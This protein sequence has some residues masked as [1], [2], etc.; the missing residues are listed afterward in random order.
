V[1][2]GFVDQQEACSAGERTTRAYVD[3]LRQ[4]R[5]PQKNAIGEWTVGDT[6]THT[7]QVF[8]MYAQASTGDGTF[9]VPTTTSL[10]DHWARRLGEE[11]GRDPAAAADRIE[12]AAQTIWPA[13]GAMTSD[14]IVEWYGGVKVPA[15][16]PPSIMITEALVHGYDIAQAEGRPWTIDAEVARISVRGLF[17]LLPEY[18][19]KEAAADVHICYELSLRGGPPAYLTF[20]N[21]AL[22]VDQSPPRPVDCKLSVDP[23][24]YLLVGYGRIGQW[25]P[26]LRGKVVAYGRKPWLGLKLGKLIASP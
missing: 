11:E 12:K 17:P 25:G 13:Y 16:T 20:E 6:A 23:A 18:V 22:S 26:T 8:E 9:P 1:G 14:R 10:N 24:T 7:A 3:L 2:T 21:G 4:A 15:F 19:N 5:N